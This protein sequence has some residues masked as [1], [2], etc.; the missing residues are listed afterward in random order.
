MKKYGFVYLW[1]DKKHKRYYV[2][3]RWGD[4]N[5]GYICS[6][7]WMLQ[8]VK[9]RPKDFKRRILTKV[10]TNRQGLL[11][12]E[13]RWLSMIKKEE[14]GKKYYNLHNHHF[15]HWSSNEKSSLTVKQKVSNTKQKFWDGPESD[16][17]RELLRQKSIENGSKPPSRL[18]K[19]SW[20]KGLTK[21]TDSRVNALSMAISK[22]KRK[23]VK[24]KSEATKQMARDNMK[25]IWT[26]RKEA[27]NKNGKKL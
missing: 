23:H 24:P 16:A 22:P 2:G 4:E 26:E 25:R 20:N 15:N 8:G 7:P 3:C 10:Y 18:G 11:E 6:S 17:M 5:D 1:Y 19:S 21:D 14:L 9:H 13:Y 12:E 27:N